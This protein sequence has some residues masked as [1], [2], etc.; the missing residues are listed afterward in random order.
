MKILW[1]TNILF[2]EAE[3]LLRKTQVD[4]KAS[5]GWLTSMADSLVENT[6]VQLTIATVCHFTKKLEVIEG[7][8]YKY[9]VFPYG[10]GN[11][12][13]NTEYETFW[14]IIDEMILPDVV[15]IHGTE[16]THGLAYVNACGNTNVVVSIQGLVS[17]ISKRY[18]A[19]ISVFDFLRT[20]TIKDVIKGHS[21]FALKEM[22]RIRG[23]YEIELLKKVHYVCGRT[24]WD[25][26]CAYNINRSIDYYSCGEIL[27]SDFYKGVWSYEGCEKHS[28]F[29]SQSYYPLKG[30][31]KV[32][33]AVS[34]VKNIYPDVQVKIAGENITCYNSIMD[35]LK[36]SG[37]GTYIRKLLKKYNLAKNVVFVGP[38]NAEEMKKHY[39]SCNVFVCSSSLENSPN[40][41]AEAQLLGVPV[42]GSYV[43]GIPDLIENKRMGI[44]YPFDDINLLAYSIC[45]VFN[46]DMD[47]DL[48]YTRQ[49]ARARH[50]EST[51]RQQ[52]LDIYNLICSKA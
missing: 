45:N 6:D 39:L 22:Y 12:K 2:P 7:N 33:E 8:K 51:I 41:I 31:H 3:S 49:R 28:I 50:C 52:L 30:L 44:L 17:E 19:G 34:L 29:L 10:N 47:I 24:T 42:I 26:A 18:M 40:S 43:G 25:R 32:I 5:G 27:R 46:N 14:K 48:E 37:Y 4:L 21:M 23:I 15:H 9:V 35:K 38:L 16:Y 1:I 13:Y 11:Y 20:L 36:I